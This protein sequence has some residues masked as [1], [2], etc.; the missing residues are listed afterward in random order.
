MR[1]SEDVHALS[2]QLHPSVLDDLGLAEGIRAEC[3]RLS[4]QESL[5]VDVDV[6]AVPGNVPREPSL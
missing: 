1:L 4:R 2:Y 6:S 5:A 3:N